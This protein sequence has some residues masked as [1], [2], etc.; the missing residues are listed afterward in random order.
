[1]SRT[2]IAD[3]D[4]PLKR[5]LDGNIDTHVDSAARHRHR[6]HHHIIAAPQTRGAKPLISRN[7]QG[8]Q[9]S[10]NN[11]NRDALPTTT[12]GARS[13][14]PRNEPSADASKHVAKL[15]KSMPMLKLVEK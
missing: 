12:N 11:L 10:A 15:H 1:M 6:H 9:R 13:W 14:R 5:I 8:T 3:E 4:E 7:V 2:P